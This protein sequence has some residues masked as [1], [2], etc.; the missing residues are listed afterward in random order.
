MPFWAVPGYLPSTDGP[1]HVYNAWVLGQLVSSAPAPLLGQY[2]YVNPQPVPNSLTHVALLALMWGLPP[3]S[4]EKALLS[5]YVLLAAGALWYL[6]GAIDGERAWLALLG[7]PFV[8][9]M[10]LGLGFYNY[11]FSV[12]LFLL[13]L[14]WW[15]RHRGRPGLAFAAV[16]DTLLVL[17]YFAHILGAVLALAGIG[18]LWLASW[19]RER[20]RGHLAH[21]AILVPGAALPFW[22][23]VLRHGG[24]TRPS[25]ETWSVLWGELAR[26]RPQWQFVAEGGRTGAILAKVF[27]A[28]LVFTLLREGVARWREAPPR[29]WLREEDG[30]LAFALLVVACYFLSP[31]GAAG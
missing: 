10:L 26:L 18:V 31:E 6:A 27:A 22:F 13:A 21:V 8:W 20:W 23:T 24:H 5:L 15:W 12:P 1:S 19:R 3:A 30:F 4:A 16:L 28:W 11:C 2:F 9:N 29:R 17:C 14:A 25:R 7:L